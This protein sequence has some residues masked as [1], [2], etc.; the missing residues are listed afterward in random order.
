MRSRDLIEADELL[1][2][3]E[4]RIAAYSKPARLERKKRNAKFRVLQ[5]KRNTQSCTEFFDAN[6]ISF[7]SKLNLFSRSI[8]CVRLECKPQFC[9]WLAVSLFWVS[10]TRSSQDVLTFQT[11]LWLLK[12]RSQIYFFA[13]AFCPMRTLSLC[14]QS[15]LVGGS[16]A[17]FFRCAPLYFQDFS[18]QK[19]FPFVV[20]L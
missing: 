19:R 6:N 12:W 10:C 4:Q 20:K 1:Q 11:F 18:S 9:V 5:E 17:F 8:F 15:I 3:D 2:T 16:R 13:G 7:F 14:S